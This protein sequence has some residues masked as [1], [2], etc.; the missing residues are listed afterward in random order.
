MFA[1]C[2]MFTP[3]EEGFELPADLAEQGSLLVDVRELRASSNLA[4]PAKTAH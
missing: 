3:T 4:A 1:L 2:G